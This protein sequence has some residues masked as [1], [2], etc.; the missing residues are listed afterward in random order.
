MWNNIS[1]TYWGIASLTNMDTYK[2]W[3]E[4][5]KQY[6]S[7]SKEKQAIADAEILLISSRG[8]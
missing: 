8:Q 6:L 4:G 5:K 1:N 3:Y 7:S 2:D